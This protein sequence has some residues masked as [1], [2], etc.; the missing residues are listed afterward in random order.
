MESPASTLPIFQ[1]DKQVQDLH[2]HPG[3]VVVGAR[4]IRRR[5]VVCERVRSRPPRPLGATF[6]LRFLLGI[7]SLPAQSGQ[8]VPLIPAPGTLRNCHLYQ[9]RIKAGV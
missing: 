9:A 3:S 6:L 7:P 1:G 8:P 5:V 2:A 4:G